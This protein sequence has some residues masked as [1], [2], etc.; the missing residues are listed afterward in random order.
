MNL[1]ECLARN[2]HEHI[3]RVHFC[4][5]LDEGFSPKKQAYATRPGEPMC[6]DSV[7]TARIQKRKHTKDHSAFDVAWLGEVKSLAEVRSKCLQD[8]KGDAPKVR[9]VAQ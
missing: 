3:H 5:P 6:H 9:F 2:A 8:M 4:P 1:V 7:R